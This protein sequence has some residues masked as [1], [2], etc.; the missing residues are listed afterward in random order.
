VTRRHSAG[1]PSVRLLT[2][3]FD[4]K[5]GAFVRLFVKLVLAAVSVASSSSFANERIPDDKPRVLQPATRYSGNTPIEM[6]NGLLFNNG[7]YGQP[8]PEYEAWAK[9]EMIVAG[10]SERPYSFAQ[11]K[12]FITTLEENIVWGE[13]AIRNWKATTNEFPDAVVYSKAAIEKMQPALDKFKSAVDKASGAKE[14]DW[15]NA[16]SEARRA[17]IDYRIAY[18]QMHK[19][20]Q[21]RQLTK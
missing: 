10:L 14:G 1:A 2:L 19:N 17:F 16:E 4:L 6:N 11:K 9:S 5:S 18:M 20:I 3:G 12:T 21:A 15:Q 7:G 13:S 8:N